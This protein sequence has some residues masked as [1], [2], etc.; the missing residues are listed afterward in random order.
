MLACILN[1]ATTSLCAAGCAVVKVLDISPLKQ[2]RLVAINKTSAI[3]FDAMTQSMVVHA[4]I[5]VNSNTE[6]F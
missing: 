3:C 6:P 5:P 2:A 1:V 4:N